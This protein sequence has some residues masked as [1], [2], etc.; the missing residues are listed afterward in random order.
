[1]SRN[2]R[3]E[4]LM[5]AMRPKTPLGDVWSALLQA[6]AS[7]AGSNAARGGCLGEQLPLAAD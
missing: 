1:M 6:P 2:E 7:L 3:A 5:A 4:G